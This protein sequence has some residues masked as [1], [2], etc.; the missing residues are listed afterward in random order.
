MGMGDRSSQPIHPSSLISS[1][2]SSLT[3]PAA[4]CLCLT[5]WLTA[6]CRSSGREFAGNSGKLHPQEREV[7]IEGIGRGSLMDS[8]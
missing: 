7:V 4:G 6:N 1:L 5:V 3:V 2:T 8:L